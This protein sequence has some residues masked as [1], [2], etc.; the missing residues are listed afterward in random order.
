MTE[1]ILS[2]NPTTVLHGRLSV[3]RAMERPRGGPRAIEDLPLT[4]CWALKAR[5][6]CRFLQKA[7]PDFLGPQCG[8]DALDLPRPA[9]RAPSPSWRSKW[10]SLGWIPR[11]GIAGSKGGASDPLIDGQSQ[12]VY[13]E[14]TLPWCVSCHVPVPGPAVDLL[15]P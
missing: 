1:Q 3:H 7:L 11:G 4:P 5:L 14:V 9:S 15:F 2:G 12:T 8:P 10:V 6:L 13:E